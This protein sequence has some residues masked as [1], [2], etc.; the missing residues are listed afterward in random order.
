ME[1]NI[2][3]SDLSEREFQV[4]ELVSIGKFN[5]EIADELQVEI[6]TVTKHLQHIFLKLDAQN[7][8]E[9]AIKFMEITG[10]LKN[11]TE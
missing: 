11:A 3:I 7:R 5:K 2:N 8:V 9:A 4:M 6:C 1:T 10:K